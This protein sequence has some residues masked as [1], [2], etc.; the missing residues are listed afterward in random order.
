[1]GFFLIVKYPPE[2]FIVISFPVLI[3]ILI[4]YLRDILKDSASRTSNQLYV[5]ISRSVASNFIYLIV[6]AIFNTTLPVEKDT[7]LSNIYSA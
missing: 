2:I 6:S 5:Y 7:N 1:M 4:L 3:I